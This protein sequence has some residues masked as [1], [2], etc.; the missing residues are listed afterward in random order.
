MNTEICSQKTRLLTQSTIRTMVTQHPEQLSSAR[1]WI[2]H[3]QAGSWQRQKPPSPTNWWMI[4]KSVSADEH[5]RTIPFGWWMGHVRNWSFY[6]VQ[7]RTHHLLARRWVTINSQAYLIFAVCNIVTSFRSG[8][9]I[10]TIKHI[11]CV[12]DICS[13]NSLTVSSRDMKFE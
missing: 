5:I 3:K 2:Y 6:N 8:P 13:S 12:C 7:W 9:C 10:L 11:I 4:C 1:R